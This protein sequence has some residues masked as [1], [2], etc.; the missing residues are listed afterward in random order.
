MGAVAGMLGTIQAAEA[1]K[2]LLGT[3]ELLVNKLLVF[4]ALKMSFR[5]VD[6]KRNPACPV[7]GDNPSLTKLIDEE[8]QVCDLKSPKNRI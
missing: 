1:L 8:Q 7:C 6:I 2:F 4:N 5:T 3:G